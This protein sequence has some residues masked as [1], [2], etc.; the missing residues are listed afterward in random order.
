M[1]LTPPVT[2]QD[3]EAVGALTYQLFD[4]PDQSSFDLFIADCLLFADS[5]MAGHMGSNYNLQE[6]GWQIA[7]QR[8]GQIYLALEAAVD[9]L[10]AKKTYGSHI[11]YISEDTAAYQSLI[12][13]NYGQ[14]A[15]Q[16]LDLW[17]TVERA[18][19][20]AFAMPTFGFAQPVPL[21]PYDDSGPTGLDPQQVQLEEA[22]STARGK[23]DTFPVGSAVR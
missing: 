15:M 23:A 17:V 13:N 14:K 9:T 11:N 7:L 16:A 22:L 1:P 2:V 6:F 19:N 5:W 18:E 8:R 4:Y 21:V 10:K 3:V 20:I 12:D